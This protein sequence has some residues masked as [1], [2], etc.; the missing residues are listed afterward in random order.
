MAKFIELHHDG[1]PSLINLEHISQINDETDADGYNA[2]L[3][4]NDNAVYLS[5]ETY[6]E[7]RTKI[8]R[9]QGCLPRF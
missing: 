2:A 5:D 3:V 1:F 7:V 4:Y 6:E 9:A 8:A